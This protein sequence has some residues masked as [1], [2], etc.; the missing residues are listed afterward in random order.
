MEHSCVEIQVLH[1]ELPAHAG[2]TEWVLALQLRPS[3]SGATQY[4]CDILDAPRKYALPL[5]HWKTP[6]ELAH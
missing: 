2:H 1:T 3:A 4:R 6:R 5:V